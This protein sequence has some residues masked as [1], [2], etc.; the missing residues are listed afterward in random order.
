MVV[1]LPWSENK[2]CDKYLLKQFRAVKEHEQLH[3]RLQFIVNDIPKSNFKLFHL[4]EDHVV[5]LFSFK[6][7]YDIWNLALMALFMLICLPK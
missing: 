7:T 2:D 4:K 1:I 6:T 3:M 5:E